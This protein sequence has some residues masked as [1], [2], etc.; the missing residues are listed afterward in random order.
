MERYYVHK[1]AANF[2]VSKFYFETVINNLQFYSSPMIF[3]NE[4]L[5]ITIKSKWRKS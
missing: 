1:V 5:K 2:A 3:V 4:Q